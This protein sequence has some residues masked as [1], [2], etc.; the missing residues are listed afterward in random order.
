MGLKIVDATPEL[1]STFNIEA[2][3]VFRVSMV[4]SLRND[5][6]GYLMIT[7]EHSAV[8]L[9]LGYIYPELSEFKDSLTKDNLIL[10]AKLV[11]GD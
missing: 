11:I 6:I 10:N 4:K 9:E 8:D 5:K 7:D 2:G 1:V 3:M